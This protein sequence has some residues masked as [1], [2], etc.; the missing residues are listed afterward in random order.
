MTLVPHN[1]LKNHQ[2]RRVARSLFPEIY[3]DPQFGFFTLKRW[4]TNPSE[5][6]PEG[7]VS[8]PLTYLKYCV[9]DPT[10][11]TMAVEVF[12][13]WEH[14]QLVSE[15]PGLQNT[16]KAL[17]S[18]RDVAI[19]SKGFKHIAQEVAAQGKN[20][21]QAAKWLA[22]KGWETD[23]IDSRRKVSRA[24]QKQ[25]EEEAKTDRAAIDLAKSLTEE[26]GL[27]KLN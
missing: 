20:S 23:V 13:D 4:N 24:Q 12:G 1:K 27:S 14:W 6:Y 26:L 9:D 21:Y 3:N 25:A 11:Y 16:I 10:E 2:N 8:F 15:V 18:E 5:D 17:R 7:L 22:E 19:K